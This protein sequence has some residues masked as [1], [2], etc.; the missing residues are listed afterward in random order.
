[1]KLHVWCVPLLLFLVSPEVLARQ[2]K[3]R[4]TLPSDCH[5]DEHWVRPHS[6]RN[7]F[8]TAYCRKNP[9]GYQFWL[10][11]ISA[12]RPKDWPNTSEPTTAWRVHEIEEVLDALAMIPLASG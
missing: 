2:V 6:K 3:G 9:N 5:P 4:P 12:K 11:K 10:P 7:A 1:M 8:F